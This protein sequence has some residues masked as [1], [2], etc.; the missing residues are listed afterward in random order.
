MTRAGWTPNAASILE[1]QPLWPGLLRG[2]VLVHTPGAAAWCSCPPHLS[3]PGPSPARVPT[4]LVLIGGH[5]NSSGL[6]LH[7]E[8][9]EWRTARVGTVGALAGSALLT[10]RGEERRGGR[11][12]REG[13]EIWREEKD[14]TVQDGFVNSSLLSSQPPTHSLLPAS[15]HLTSDPSRFPSSL[16]LLFSPLSL[17][18]PPRPSSVCSTV[19]AEGPIKLLPDWQ[20]GAISCANRTG[21]V[22]C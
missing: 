19:W 18:P 1:R 11:G 12:V 13:E 16:R 9:E 2:P 22:C 15:G 7:G 4:S 21:P 6:F 8:R 10:R 5:V 14:S 17:L 20:V 3:W